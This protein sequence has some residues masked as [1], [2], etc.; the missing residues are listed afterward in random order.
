MFLQG[1]STVFLISDSQL[2]DESFLE[3]INNI[4]NTGEVCLPLALQSVSSRSQP[5]TAHKSVVHP[6]GTAFQ[7]RRV[8]Q[9][10]TGVQQATRHTKLA[11]SCSSAQSPSVPLVAARMQPAER[12]TAKLHLERACCLSG[13]CPTCSPRTS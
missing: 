4:L 3:D 12:D 9:L 7:L 6:H 1:Q 2:K 13:R 11:V 8:Q 5:S 10:A